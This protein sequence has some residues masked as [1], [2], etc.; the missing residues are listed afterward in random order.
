MTA[1]VRVVVPFDLDLLTDVLV[2]APQLGRKPVEE[3]LHDRRFAEAL[4][5]AA[6]AQENMEQ[7]AFQDP[8]DEFSMSIP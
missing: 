1:A 8:G 3:A 6:L 7:I 5:R 2:A 4:Y